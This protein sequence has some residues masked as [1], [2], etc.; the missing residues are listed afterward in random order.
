MQIY[1]F[2]KIGERDTKNPLIISKKSHISGT[3]HSHPEGQPASTETKPGLVQHCHRIGSSLTS[4]NCSKGQQKSSPQTPSYICRHPPVPQPP[5]SWNT[6]LRNIIRIDTEDQLLEGVLSSAASLLCSGNDRRRATFSML[7]P[8]NANKDRD[9]QGR[10][11]DIRR[12]TGLLTGKQEILAQME[13][14]RR[15][16][17]CGKKGYYSFSD[18]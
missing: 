9:D 11:W 5:W 17:G 2:S 15:Q 8:Q 14:E 12:C 13:R 3:G 1:I 18:R 6:P 16:Q 10:K 4:L 7:S